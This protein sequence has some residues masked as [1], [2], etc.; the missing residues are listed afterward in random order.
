MFAKIKTNGASE[1][2]INIPL[3]GAE[4]SLPALAAMLE[5]NA[6]FIQRGYR[7]IKQVHPDTTFH[8]GDSIKAEEGS[9]AEVIITIPQSTKV[10]D[11]S[12][13]IASPEAF[14]SCAKAI[15]KRD[16]EIQ[17]VKTENTFYKSENERLKE[18]L[19]ALIDNQPIEEQ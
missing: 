9:E 17:K 18:Q 14:I 16:E 19:K 1:I 6:I 11:D 3:D 10:L 5:Q 8:L 4:K 15:A 13:M 12:F 7:D 2:I